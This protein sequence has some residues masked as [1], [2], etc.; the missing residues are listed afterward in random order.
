M[1][2]TIGTEVEELEWDT[3]Y[4]HSVLGINRSSFLVRRMPENALRQFRFTKCCLRVFATPARPWFV[5]Y[6]HVYMCARVRV[7][8]PQ[9]VTALVTTLHIC[10]HSWE[11]SGRTFLL[12]EVISERWLCVD[13]R[14]LAF[15][16]T[17][18]A[19]AC[20]CTLVPVHVCICFCVS[21]CSRTRL[22]VWV[23]VCARV[24]K[25]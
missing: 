13:A 3:P 12:F 19:Y 2:V 21:A 17:N 25:T 16:Y 24:P 9:H 11:V 20:E 4:Y 23:F 15:A 6:P 5:A 18:F 14:V 1:T 22:Y 8:V 10:A 7:C